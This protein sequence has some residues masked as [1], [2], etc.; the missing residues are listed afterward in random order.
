MA[1][2]LDFLNPHESNPDPFDS[3]AYDDWEFSIGE[4]VIFDNN[5][6]D[7]IDDGWHNGQMAIITDY[8]SYDE[9]YDIEFGD[10]IQL[11]AISGQHLL[12]II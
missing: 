3:F 7:D 12:G 10:G 4:I 5:G 8:S 9:Y 11:T 6:N 2:P 1:H